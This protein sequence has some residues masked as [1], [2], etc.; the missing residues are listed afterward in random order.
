[1]ESTKAIYQPRKRTDLTDLLDKIMA[2]KNAIKF[3]IEI[4]K[5][6]LLQ[7]KMIIALEQKTIWDGILSF[8]WSN[9]Q[10]IKRLKRQIEVSKLVTTNE[11]CEK[12]TRVYHKN[13][14]LLED[15]LADVYK[16]M[17]ERYDFYLA[18]LMELHEKFRWGAPCDPNLPDMDIKK[19]VAKFES[20]PPADKVEK[21]TFYLT[22]EELLYRSS[23]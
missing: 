6:I 22:M 5:Q 8:F 10:K 12:Q 13:E 2:L 11:N 14:L 16:E 4:E 18:S 1:M 23:K 3:K 21:L 9:A 20:A 7:S 15:E 19:I 17:D